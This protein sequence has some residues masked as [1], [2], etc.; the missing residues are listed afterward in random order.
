MTR[1]A[2]RMNV[3]QSALSTQIRQLGDRLG[4]AFFDRVG[5]HLLLIEVGRIALNHAD[6]IFGA[7]AAVTPAR[8]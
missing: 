2:E 4:H 6:R 8:R 1:A 5:R 7:G 3:S